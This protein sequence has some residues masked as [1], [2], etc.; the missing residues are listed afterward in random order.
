M[1]YYLLGMLLTALMAGCSQDTGKDE[2]SAEGI[3]VEQK[4]EKSAGKKS[5]LICLDED[6]RIICKLMTKRA[7]RERLVEFIWHSPGSTD[8][9]ER[10]LT[11]PENHASTFDTRHKSG[12]EKGQWEVTAKID[13]EE[14][15]AVFRIE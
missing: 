10:T 1:K 14:V 13:N 15:S 7:D 11:L 9:R 4:V 12:R 5:A 6:D 2:K 8:D 3:K